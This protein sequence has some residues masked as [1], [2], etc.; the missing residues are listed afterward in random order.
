MYNMALIESGKVVRHA[1]QKVKVGPKI[2]IF[3]M[4]T[5]RTF[6]LNFVFRLPVLGDGGMQLYFAVTGHSGPPQNPVSPG[7]IKRQTQ[8]KQHNASLPWA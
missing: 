2:K 4:Q 3:F 6:Y 1:L 8:T 7:T 5:Q